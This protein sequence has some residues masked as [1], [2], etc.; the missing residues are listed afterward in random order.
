MERLLKKL[1]SYR[2]ILRD[3]GEL[4][5]TRYYIFRKPVWWMPSIY[6]HCFH[7]SD[8]DEELHNH[9]W[10]RSLSL[11]LKGSYKEEYREN[12]QVKS[13]TLK[14]GCCN[15]I[16]KDTFHRIDL[17]TDK[18]WTLFI[19]GTKSNPNWGFWDR[20][21]DQYVSHQE[22]EINKAANFNA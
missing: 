10:N 7:S 9:G 14:A 3:D 19:S 16:T 22:H 4:Y 2:T 8:H 18:V 5:L 12:N 15:Y 1:F 6:I 21:T 13:R 20:H 11:I 17:V